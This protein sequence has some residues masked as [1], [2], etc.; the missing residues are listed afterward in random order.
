MQPP[1]KLPR[2]SDPTPPKMTWQMPLGAKLSNQVYSQ[3]FSCVVQFVL[4]KASEEPNSD[5]LTA[6]ADLVF[7]TALAL[8]STC[9]AARCMP[10]LY[11][12]ACLVRRRDMQ[13]L[14][15][16]YLMIDRFEHHVINYCRR[17]NL[18][19][20]THWARRRSWTFSDKLYLDGQ[21]F[22]NTA[23][24]FTYTDNCDVLC[25]S[26]DSFAELCLFAYHWLIG[27]L[28][29]STYYPQYLCLEAQWHTGEANNSIVIDAKQVQPFVKIKLLSSL[30]A[31]GTLFPHGSAVI[32]GF[33]NHSEYSWF[34][35]TCT[36]AGKRD[37][38]KPLDRLQRYLH[39]WYS[40]RLTAPDRVNFIPITFAKE[41]ENQNVLFSEW[42]CQWLSAGTQPQPCAQE[43]SDE[44]C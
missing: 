10:A 11:R 19:Y 12:L 8:T 21:W 32:N 23:T 22:K 2:V 29:G 35:A 9:R 43:Q 4:Q 37:K 15:P 27:I 1:R 5:P 41:D 44:S 25:F 7:R 13:S 33:L 16:A 18:P 6:D 40:N 30:R 28:K 20:T 34:L 17:R 26:T 3:V 42:P 38:K 24:C 31:I 39:Q 36:T 14:T